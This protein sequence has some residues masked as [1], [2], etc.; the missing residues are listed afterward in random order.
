MKPVTL[1]MS[2]LLS[3][4]LRASLRSADLRRLDGAAACLGDRV[5][6][7]AAGADLAE[8]RHRLQAD[9]GQRALV[10]VWKDLHELAPCLGP[11]IE[12]FAGAKTP[13]PFV[14]VSDQ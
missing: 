4:S 3:F 14:V 13:R 10:F 2:A 7:G 11:V 5:L 9:L 8:R 12:D 6:C 1:P